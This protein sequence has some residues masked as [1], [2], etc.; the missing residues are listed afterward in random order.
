MVTEPMVPR[1]PPFREV[2][3]CTPYVPPVPAN[4]Y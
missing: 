2:T 4:L 3:T 1:I